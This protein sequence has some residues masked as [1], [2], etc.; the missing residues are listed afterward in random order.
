[1]SLDNIKSQFDLI[2]LIANPKNKYSKIILKS[3]DKKLIDTLC[4][5]I[6]N[7]LS[8]KIQIPEEDKIK[9]IKFR[10]A[11]ENLF[12][13]GTSFK[14]RRKILVQKGGLLQFILPAVITGIAS[15]ISAAVQ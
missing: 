8:G 15:I 4:E 6:F 12:N 9:L 13:K 14:A 5:I 1:M 10:K 7:V 2:K 11:L 3:G